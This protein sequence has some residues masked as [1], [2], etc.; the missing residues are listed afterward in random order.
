MDV[1]EQPVSHIVDLHGSKRR[2][3][4]LPSKGQAY[5]HRENGPAIEF[6][7]SDG[8]FDNGTRLWCV[9]CKLHRV[10]GPAVIFAYGKEEWWIN[11][12]KIEQPSCKLRAWIEEE[13]IDLK[14]EEGQIAFI[15][16][17]V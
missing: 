14:T 7:D 1:K 2:E 3:W 15:L 4:Y 13:N 11:D 16:R 12:Q 8:K 17:W 9:D 10:D 5:W 6:M